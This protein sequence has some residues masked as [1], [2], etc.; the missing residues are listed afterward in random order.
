MNILILIFTTM[1]VYGSLYGYL[2]AALISLVMAVFVN[3]AR[4][5]W[6]QQDQEQ[7]STAAAKSPCKQL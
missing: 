6:Q 4:R 5:S 7:Q 1:A 2:G 3:Y